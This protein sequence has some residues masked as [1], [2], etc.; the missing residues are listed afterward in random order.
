MLGGASSLPHKVGSSSRIHPVEGVFVQMALHEAPIGGSALLLEATARAIGRH[1]SDIALLSVQLLAQQSASCRA[2]QRIGVGLVD[3]GGPV[4]QIAVA[5]TVHRP[6]G[7]N[8][9]RDAVNLAG[10]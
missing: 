8:A 10:L 5:L 2:A 6:I 1:I 9:R 3:E 4:E 7:R